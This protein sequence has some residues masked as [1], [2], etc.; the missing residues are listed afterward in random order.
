VDDY[1]KFTW[2]YFLRFKPEVF[3]KIRD[4]QNLVERLFDR[5]I[6]VVQTDWGGEYEALHHFF[7]KIGI[8]H[9]VSCPHDHQQNGSAERKHRHIVEVGLSL[10]AHA[11]MPLKF[12][13]EA[14]LVALYLINQTPS[15]VTDFSI[16]LERLDHTKPDYSSL[17]ISGCA[18]WPYLRP[19]NKR[20]LEFRSK[21]CVF[22]G[23]SNLHKGFKCLDV[24]TRRVY[25]SH[26]VIFV[27]NIFP[28]S[29]LHANV[30]SRV[31]EEVLL[32]PSH[33]LNPLGGESLDNHMI[34]LT[35]NDLVEDVKHTQPH[36]G[37]EDQGVGPGADPLTE[38][39]S[40]SLPYHTKSPP[41][42][43]QHHSEPA[44]SISSPPRQS[45]VAMTPTEPSRAASGQGEDQA[46][47]LTA[48]PV[49][50][51]S[52]PTTSGVAPDG[53]RQPQLLR[54]QQCLLILQFCCSKLRHHL[55]AFG[56][57]CK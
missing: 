31:R 14:F 9:L 15:T 36:A 7:M 53:S 42:G 29:K 26:D 38:S 5:K 50:A 39:P 33:L 17:R 18:C 41:T 13:D 21:E 22:L 12:W 56:L 27:E 52:A 57:G 2:I 20:K 34:N 32:L 8:S 49:A 11:Q 35:S 28:F 24:K 40:G 48:A 10:L 37:A 43:T 45:R 1:S 51:S 6:L 16:P 47:P 4:F 3:Q 19:Y 23:Y 30:G 54:P 55:L 44:M 46:V 25:I